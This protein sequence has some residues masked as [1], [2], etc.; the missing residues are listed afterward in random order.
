MLNEVKLLIENFVN[1]NPLQPLH[2]LIEESFK[3]NKTAVVTKENILLICKNVLLDNINIFKEFQLSRKAFENDWVKER[4]PYLIDKF[5]NT[6]MENP[7][8]FNFEYSDIQEKILFYYSK[9]IDQVNILTTLKYEDV[10]DNFLTN[11]KDTTNDI[12]VN[13]EKVITELTDQYKEYDNKK[14]QF[15]N[16]TKYETKNMILECNENI[17]ADFI[18]NSNYRCHYFNIAKSSLKII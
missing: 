16:D 10:N 15:I 5:E 1:N 14:V 4:I 6:I 7:Q 8:Y 2:F 9:Q 18:I 12:D 17:D 11:W 3:A 13:L